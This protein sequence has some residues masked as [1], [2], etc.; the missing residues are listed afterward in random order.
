VAFFNL[1]FISLCGGI[2]WRL[3]PERG[4]WHHSSV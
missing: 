4:R 2:V 1:Q 3:P